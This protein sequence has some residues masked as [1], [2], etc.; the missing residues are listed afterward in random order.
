MNFREYRQRRVQD[1]GVRQFCWGMEA[2]DIRRM[3]DPRHFIATYTRGPGVF[4]I[5]EDMSIYKY[6][7]LNIVFLDNQGNET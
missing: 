3:I 4:W 2:V 5:S 7:L 1:A 6:E